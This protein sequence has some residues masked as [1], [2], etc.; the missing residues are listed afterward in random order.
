MGL[1]TVSAASASNMTDDA[2]S[3]LNDEQIILDDALGSTSNE[4]AI[5]EDSDDGS[6]TALQ[7]KIDNAA[8]G[9]TITLTKDYSYNEESDNINWISISKPL[10]IDGEGHTID[11]MS[12]AELITV[13]SKVTLNNITFKNGYS[14]TSGP[15]YVSSSGELSLNHC[16]FINCEAKSNGGAVYAYGNDMTISNC[17]FYDCSANSGGAVY[18][19][20]N[21]GVLKNSNFINCHSSGLGGAIEW[22][23]SHGIV[24]YC[25]FNKCYANF[26]GA[27]HIYA[28][29]VGFMISN[30]N[31]DLCSASIDGGA[32]RMLASN[33]TVY[34]CKFNETS[35]QKGGAISFEGI[36][37]SI[38]MSD[39][40]SCYSSYDYVSEQNAGGAIFFS[41]VVKD[42]RISKCKFF[43]CFADYGGA[44]F[45]A[46]DGAIVENCNFDSCHA[47]LG[48]GAVVAAG[49][50][51]Q[52]NN[53]NFSNCQAGTSAG[54]IL[55]SGCEEGFIKNCQFR[56]CYSGDGGAI[57][58]SLCKNIIVS[59]SD[60]F[61][62]SSDFGGAIIL[63]G[64]D[65]IVD[66]CNFE[67]CSSIKKGG[68]IYVYATGVTISNN[69]FKNCSS[70][71]G[72]A[73]Y[74]TEESYNHSI[75]N[76]SFSHCEANSAGAMSVEN[77]TGYV[78]GCNFTDCSSNLGVFVYMGEKLSKCNFKNCYSGSTFCII[79]VGD[80]I[81]YC[82]FDNCSCDSNSCIVFL[83]DEIT[84]CNFS[85]CSSPFSGAVSLDGKSISYCNFEDCSGEWGGAIYYDSNEGEVSNCN[86]KNCVA[87]NSAG[88]VYLQ[89]NDFSIKYCSFNNCSAKYGGAVYSAGSNGIMDYCSFEDCSA[90]LSGGAMYFGFAR[91]CIFN[92]C[93]AKY[94]G[95][96][97]NISAFD[98]NFTNNHA[99][100]GGAMYWGVANDRCVF[101]NN[102]ENYEISIIAVDLNVSDFKSTFHSGDKLNI[103][104]KVDGMEVDDAEVIV[105]VYENN[106]WI[107]DYSCLSG[108]GWV[109]DLPVGVYDA[110]CI[111]K[112]N[113]YPL[114]CVKV[115]LTV[116]QASTQLIA[117]SISTVCNVNNNLVITLKDN[118]GNSIGGVD[119]LINFNG[120]K[121][122]KTNANGQVILATGNMI[123]NT[124][125]VSITFAG[126]DNYIKST[127]SVNVA[128]AKANLKLSA[129][130]KTF[131]KKVK[132]KKYTVTL[133]NNVNKPLKNI[134]L[135]LKI[136]GK[137]FAATTNAKG[138]ATFKIKK[139]NKKAKL[140]ATITFAGDKCYNKLSKTV[141]ITIK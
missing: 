15:L 84:Y 49:E 26:G 122:L 120:A 68:A 108:N 93:N 131:K 14:S 96:A 40:F 51:Y 79:F 133:K 60:F 29:S 55:S 27:I 25:D 59:Y 111:V 20:G 134:K 69:R 103:D 58:I 8:S 105:K 88:A 100:Q 138:K 28:V 30:S 129:A 37:C 126:N 99:T 95:A 46:S 106:V 85:Q 16:D 32:I 81:S 12:K 11:A 141:K 10:T 17:N 3:E 4:S 71:T 23:G 52:I 64:E 13:K 74:L 87:S 63:S 77:T 128:V 117:S 34:K 139:F 18:V 6:F 80:V 7:N 136:K 19:Y 113:G 94:G 67:D 109:V 45:S 101:K 98:C 121:T 47:N 65:S 62:C 44:V 127:K 135:K 1:V 90:D 50:D 73:I 2:I 38:L 31:F 104:L 56:N 36:N 22:A 70:N 102:D 61:N 123:P 24:D 130:K 76:S 140:K 89:G 5:L 41:N 124:Y 110:V 48:A 54:A 91:N 116:T 115:T 92:N 86:F 118:K 42:V 43:D 132:T 9:S 125:P 72:G 33:S 97:L 57:R 39:F 35:S 83:G 82:T 119:L 75:I 66:N 21:G 78:Y 112:N 114:N 53:C 107:G 137:T